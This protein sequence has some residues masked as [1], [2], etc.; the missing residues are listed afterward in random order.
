MITN[1]CPSTSFK[2][3]QFN[4]KVLADLNYEGFVT[5]CAWLSEVR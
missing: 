5:K 2:V 4:T 1:T 3:N